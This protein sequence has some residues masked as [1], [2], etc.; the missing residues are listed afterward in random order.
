MM[1]S[2]DV[3]LLF[4]E[5]T[6]GHEQITSTVTSTLSKLIRQLSVLYSTED[7]HTMRGMYHYSHSYIDLPARLA[8]GLHSSMVRLRPDEQLH[9]VPSQVNR[10]C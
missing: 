7:S 5:N 10:A 2:Y 1:Q 8:H 6:S 3:S 4:L 9:I